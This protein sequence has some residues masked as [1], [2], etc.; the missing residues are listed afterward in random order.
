MKIDFTPSYV[1]RFVTMHNSACLPVAF[2]AYREV[3]GASLGDR[4]AA[5]HRKEANGTVRGING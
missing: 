5:R 3:S 4:Q 1:Q 2:T